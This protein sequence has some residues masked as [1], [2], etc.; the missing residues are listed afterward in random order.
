MAYK[1]NSEVFPIEF[2]FDSVEQPVCLRHDLFLLLLVE[3]VALVNIPIVL[4]HIQFVIGKFAVFKIIS[5]VTTAQ[6]GRIAKVVAN[7]VFEFCYFFL[8][9]I[10]EYP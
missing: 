1:K 9:E 3:L 7:L 2:V 6:R 10:V 4:S 8:F 5:T